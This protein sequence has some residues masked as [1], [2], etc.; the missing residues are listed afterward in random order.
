MNNEDFDN[1]FEAKEIKTQSEAKTKDLIDYIAEDLIDQFTFKHFVKNGNSIGLYRW[2]GKRF[3]E[4]EEEIKALIEKHYSEEHKIT[5]HIVNEVIEKIKRKT[6]HELTEDN[7]LVIA[8]DNGI[9]DYTD[10]LTDNV[11]L[12]SFEE[13]SKE[14]RDGITNIIPFIHIPHE[15]DITLL[16]TLFEHKDVDIENEKRIIEQLEPEITNIFKQWTNDKWLIL[17]EIIGFS[18]YP[19]YAIPKA[20]MLYGEGSNG[21]TTF[22]NLLVKILSEENITNIALQVLCNEHYRFSKSLLYNKLANIYDDLPK[23]PIYEMGAFKMLTGLSPIE[24]DRKFREPIKF[25]NFAKMIF[26]TNQLPKISDYTLAN[27]RRWILIEFPNKFPNN[28]FFFDTV[29]TEEKIKRI[30]AISI[31]TF[32]LALKRNSF[33]YEIGIEEI[34]EKWRRNSEPLYDFIESMIEQKILIRDNEGKVEKEYLY[35]LYRKWCNENDISELKKREF[36]I[37]LEEYGITQIHDGKTNQFYY[38]G[39]RK[40]EDKTQNILG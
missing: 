29:F 14:L 23:N 13:Y 9:F 33:S 30:I 25:Y 12:K 4:C 11:Y 6:Y 20:F 19:K 2:D 7:N 39:L 24:A 36:T 35:E 27:L 32:Y 31:W 28:A 1:E 15:L 40:A 34:A 18:L 37:K 26:S 38:K 10:L 3:V 17:Y 22:V 21:K 5:N 8:F 16:K